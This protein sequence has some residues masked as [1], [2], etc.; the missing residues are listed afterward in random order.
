MVRP[1]Y[2]DDFKCTGDKCSFTCCQG[3]EIL[4]DSEACRRR[5]TDN[6]EGLLPEVLKVRP[7]DENGC[8]FQTD[9]GLCSIVMEEGEDAIPD[10]CIT[11]PRIIYEEETWEEATLSFSCPGV[12][13]LL[14]K[15]LMENG[16][17]VEN[18]ISFKMDEK[19]KI[20][21]EPAETVREKLLEILKNPE[22]ETG[23]ALI[24]G[25]QYVFAIWESKGK[26]NNREE[27]L[28][29]CENTEV[30][31]SYKFWELKNLFLDI[32][33]NYKKL[34]AYAPLLAELS[35]YGDNARKC[36]NIYRDMAG[37][38]A[39]FSEKYG[40]LLKIIMVSKIFESCYNEDIEDTLTGL[41]IVI[42]EYVM[43]RFASF[44]KWEMNGK[45]EICYEDVRDYVMIF[46]R[47]IGNN[48]DSYLGFLEDSFGNRI[49]DAGYIGN[50]LV[51]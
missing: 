41:E 36:R 43:A 25:Y 29:E 26:E 44:L 3:W 37:F 48:I 32:T 33:E 6:T 45:Q 24:K 12:I 47:I 50:L 51:I 42:S 27:S 8:P 10:T 2:Y 23:Q 31:R 46:S 4:L 22:L 49:L 7:E 1:V 40:N 17:S 9:T 38:H 30:S 34:P 16:E 18:L 20:M 5:F 13:D 11:F 28:V 19:D 21:P 14:W 35:E 15:K 39:V